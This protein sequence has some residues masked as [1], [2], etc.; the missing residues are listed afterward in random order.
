MAWGYTT[1]ARPGPRGGKGQQGEKGM[2]ALDTGGGEGEE[3]PAVWHHN[4]ALQG[5]C[6]V[7]RRGLVAEGGEV[8]E[9]QPAPCSGLCYNRYHLVLLK[10]YTAGTVFPL[11]LPLAS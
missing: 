7:G 9:H 4:G 3:S 8:Q 10:F 5:F 11:S 6:K 2:T 1:K